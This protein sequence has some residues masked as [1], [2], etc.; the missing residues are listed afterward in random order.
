MIEITIKPKRYSVS[1]T[2]H[3]NY[4]KPGRDIVCAAA[5]M[6][7]Y[8]L[9]ETVTSYPDKVFECKPYTDTGEKNVIACTPKKEY[10][11]NFDV[12]Y[13]TIL[14]G[15]MLLKEHYPDNVNVTIK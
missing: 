10:R 13:Q 6:L 7:F 1:M 9:A 2:G 3:A 15:F 4:G 14:N 5:S 12:V 11:P 8:T